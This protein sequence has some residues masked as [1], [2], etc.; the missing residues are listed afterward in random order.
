MRNCHVTTAFGFTGIP[1]GQFQ[2]L[3]CILSNKNILPLISCHL[4][5]AH[6]PLQFHWFITNFFGFEHQKKERLQKH[7]MEQVHHVNQLLPIL[8]FKAYCHWNQT[9]RYKR[10]HEDTVE[11]ITDLMCDYSF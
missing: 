6:N 4:F 8:R 7:H 9:S 11:V 1:C 3:Q 2:I 5:I 10:L